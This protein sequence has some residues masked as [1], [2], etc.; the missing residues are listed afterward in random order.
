M[1]SAVKHFAYFIEGRRVHIYTDHK[2]LTFAFAS[3]SER[4]TAR[5]QRHLSLIAEYTT[6]VR[7]IQGRVNV[8]ADA[9]SRVELEVNQVCV[10]NNL[11]DI[12]L[13]KMAE[14]QQDDV[15][16]Q[17]YRTAIS[18]L[19]LA[20]LPIPGTNTTLLCDTST[21]APRP[22]VPRS[23]RRTVFNTIHGLAHSLKCPQQLGTST[24]W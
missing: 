16:V 5:Q 6:D 1:Y 13:V 23:W 11:P 10:N 8:V 3:G 24:C 17:A 18:K 15:Q 14:A 21:G 4:W 9:L 7:H 20:D 19:V 22:I 12:D 2:P